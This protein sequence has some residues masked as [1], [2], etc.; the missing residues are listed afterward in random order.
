MTKIEF[1]SVEDWYSCIPC[2]RPVWNN[3]FLGLPI[4]TFLESDWLSGRQ[5]DMGTAWYGVY[6][7]WDVSGDDFSRS[8]SLYGFGKN[9]GLFGPHD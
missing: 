1:R 8:K 3:K 7:K 5:F 4:L 6:D 2:K 9:L